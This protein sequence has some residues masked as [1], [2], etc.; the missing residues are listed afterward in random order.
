MALVPT[1]ECN[2]LDCYNVI[3][4]LNGTGYLDMD[5]NEI[6]NYRSQFLNQS[7]IDAMT[8]YEGREAF[9]ST[10]HKKGYWN[11]S[12]MVYP[13]NARADHSGTQT[14][15]T[16]SDFNEAAV[17]AV[18]AVLTDTYS[19]DMT[20]D[21]N[22][23]IIK[24][25]I[26]LASGS[27][28]QITS[29]GI[30]LTNTGVIAGT[31]TKY[32]VDAQGRILTA[33]N[34]IATDLPT[35]NSMHTGMRLSEFASPNANLDF[36]NIRITN[37]ADPVNSQDAVN[38]R[39]LL[40][41][42]EGL[43]PKGACRVIATTNITLSGSQVIDTETVVTNDRA[44]LTGQS[45]PAENGFWVVNSGGAWARAADANVWSELVGAHTFIT[46]GT[47]NY[48]NTGWLCT[49]EQG[50][51]LGVTAVTFI[52][53][54]GSGTIV[55]GAGLGK[56]GN[57]LFVKV[58]DQTIKID[59]DVIKA[60]LLTS[61]GI[62]SQSGGM[63]LDCDNSTI[64]LVGGHLSIIGDYKLQKK[65][66]EVTGNGSAKSF[67]FNHGV[68]SLDFVLMGRDYDTGAEVRPG[69]DR[70]DAN[71]INIVFGVAPALNK[72]YYFT[73]IG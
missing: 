47:A 65:V 19:V 61:G 57:E 26:I 8:K 45:N 50:G 39:T 54:T 17:D 43:N 11:G 40:A 52:Q 21:D 63:Y 41:T 35:H 23:N 30:K 29:T 24:A 34:L 33:S 67:A 64:G 36:N 38:L 32:E 31:Y 14:A 62:L 1:Q 53:F 28:M 9:N 49:V 60:K 3:R 58:D 6:K 46:E 73:L 66:K 10:L 48:K 20:Y 71:N 27:G 15:A 13:S 2:Q 56:T 69:I 7:E 55:D 5:G 18:G 59:S 51:T 70:V 4:I 16:I 25:D 42:S 37:L 68:N 12:A 44:L 72:K 22:N